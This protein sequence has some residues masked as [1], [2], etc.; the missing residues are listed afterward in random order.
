M[1]I[2]ACRYLLIQVMAFQIYRGSEGMGDERQMK[3][4][5]TPSALVTCGWR[6]PSLLHQLANLLKQRSL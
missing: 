1:L 5:L 4:L 3:N 2:R 6:M